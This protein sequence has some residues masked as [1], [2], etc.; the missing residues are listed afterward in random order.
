[1][2]LI[3]DGHSSGLE[4]VFIKKNWSNSGRILRLHIHTIERPQ[5]LTVIENPTAATSILHCHRRQ[6]PNQQTRHSESSMYIHLQSLVLST[7]I[8]LGGLGLDPP[9]IGLIIAPSS[10]EVAQG[11]VRIISLR[12]FKCQFEIMRIYC[13]TCI[14][15][16]CLPYLDTNELSREAASLFPPSPQRPARRQ[17]LCHTSFSGCRSASGCIALAQG[18]KG[19]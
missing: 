14:L 19:E 6:Y 3:T 7:P 15:F 11:F 10:Y 17:H 16:Y 18:S 9:T 5:A 12:P 4:L 2:A 8:S 1:M 13:V